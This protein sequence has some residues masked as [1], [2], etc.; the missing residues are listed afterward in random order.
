[1]DATRKRGE[2]RAKNG[3]SERLAMDI[4][5]RLDITNVGREY[6]YEIH[7]NKGGNSALKINEESK[8]SSHA[9]ANFMDEVNDQMPENVRGGVIPTLKSTKS[10]KLSFS[11]LWD[12]RRKSQ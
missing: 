1:L 10:R 2:E 5:Q 12:A 7:P 6:N 8:R 11:S 3:K 4:L 9:V